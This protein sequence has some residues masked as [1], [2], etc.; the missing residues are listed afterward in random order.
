MADKY[1]IR[2][3]RKQLHIYFESPEGCYAN[4]TVDW[5]VSINRKQIWWNDHFVPDRHCKHENHA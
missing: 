5:M 1:F 4:D 3:G 2:K